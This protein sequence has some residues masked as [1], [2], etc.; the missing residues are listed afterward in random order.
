MTLGTHPEKL[1]LGYLRNQIL[2]QKPTEIE[3]VMVDWEREVAEVTTAAGKGVPIF[4]ELKRT[5]TT[6][7]GQGT[8]LSCTLDKLYEHRLPDIKIKQSDIYAALMAVSRCNKSTA[9]PARCTVAD[10]ARTGKC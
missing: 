4:D 5:V 3:S 2:F 1:T 10:C 7:C 6:G 9:P 8:I